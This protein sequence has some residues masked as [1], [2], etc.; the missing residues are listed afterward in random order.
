M[1]AVLVAWSSWFIGFH[2]CRRLLSEWYTV[3][4]I[5]NE[6]D[7][8]DVALKKARREVL[9]AEKWFHFHLW[10]VTDIPFLENIF[11]T[12]QIDKVCTLAAQAWVRYS[13]ENP[14]AFINTNIVGFHNLIFMAKLHAC[15]NFVYA[16]TGSVYWENE[17]K[18][19]ELTD[20]CDKPLS[21]YAATKKS[22]ELIAHSYSHLHGLQ[23]IG[24]RF[25]NVV[26]PWWRPD[27]AYHIF[28]NNIS[29]WIPIKV[30][31]HWK[32]KRNNTYVWDIVD[33]I[34]R[35]LEYD[36]GG[37]YEVFNLW[38][39]REVDLMYFIE[40]IEKRIWKVAE[41]EYIEIQP[42]EVTSNTVDSSVT[43]KTLWRK[44]NVQIEK[45]LE[46]AVDWQRS[47]YNL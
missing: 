5:D 34:V 26:W 25:F 1:K 36:N 16:S 4:W 22:D 47:F 3:I 29:K 10:N 43:Y 15:D 35:S 14:Y 2:L 19:W 41:K 9:L 13:F 23:T 7:Y 32:M 12:H 31:N 20:A 28:T 37:K 8:Y 24:L 44:A 38:N 6:N 33:G 11:S 45:M 46:E 17:W 40:C 18:A 30:Y 21:L 39:E 27:A 42:G